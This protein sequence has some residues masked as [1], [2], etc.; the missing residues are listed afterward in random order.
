LVNASGIIG[1]VCELMPQT[2]EK[3]KRKPPSRV[4]TSQGVPV[5]KELDEALQAAKVVGFS[6]TPLQLL[7]V[8]LKLA[9]K[10]RI[11]DAEIDQISSIYYDTVKKWFA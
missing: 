3:R 4:R 10:E 7:G 1:S 5:P 6:L 9:L 11:T 8:V 2:T